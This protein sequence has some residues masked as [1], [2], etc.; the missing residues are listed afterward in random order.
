MQ[1]RLTKQI[2]ELL[3]KTLHPSG[4]AIVIEANHLCMTI[5]SPQAK[6]S[7][8]V[9][10]CFSGVLKDPTSYREEFLSLIGKEKLNG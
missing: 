5:N 6:E 10:T 8:L 9:T 3:E 4:V 1:E 2:A 7:T